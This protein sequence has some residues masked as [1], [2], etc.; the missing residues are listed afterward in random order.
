VSPTDNDDHYHHGDLANTLRLVA[1]DVISERGAAGFSLR[2]VAR[3]AGVS[4]AAPTHHFGDATGLLTAVAVDGFIHLR[5]A[6][7]AAAEGIDDPVE[8]LTAIARA[9]VEVSRSNPGHCAVI[10]RH[11]LIDPTNADYQ[12]AGEASYDDLRGAIR[13]IA[14]TLNP[15]LDVETAAQLCW[16]TMQGLVQLYSSMWGRSQTTPGA[17]PVPEVGDLAETFARLIVDGLLGSSS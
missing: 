1:A 5:Q 14:E 17:D 13:E 16:S 3:R 11:D 8:R 15:S 10:F 9:Y 4:H 7:Q 12:R 2:E 6:T